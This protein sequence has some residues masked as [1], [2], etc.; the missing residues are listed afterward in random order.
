MSEAIAIEMEEIKGADWLTVQNLLKDY[1]KNL[2]SIKNA[3]GTS[4][5]TKLAK[6][7][8]T[9]Y[10]AAFSS[11][12]SKKRTTWKPA[13]VVKVAEAFGITLKVTIDLEFP[14]D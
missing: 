13:T 14:E 6:A 4:P 3:K 7:T 11:I 10:S 1:I 2:G 5:Y 12:N 9:Q 8:G